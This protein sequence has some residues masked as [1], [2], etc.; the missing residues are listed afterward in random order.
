MLGLSRD[1]LLVVVLIAAP[2]VV[3]WL[4]NPKMEN[5]LRTAATCHEVIEH[6]KAKQYRNLAPA[7]ETNMANCDS[8]GVSLA[9][10]Y[11]GATALSSPY[12]TIVTASVR[13]TTVPRNAVE[14]PTGV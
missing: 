4:T 3:A 14:P 5:F 11:G 7:E 8:D 13:V 10:R 2:L 12:L 9:V 6:L 1:L